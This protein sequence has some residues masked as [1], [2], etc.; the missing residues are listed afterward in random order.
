V[1][2]EAATRTYITDN[3]AHWDEYGFGTWA[4]YAKD[5]ALRDKAGAFA[6]RCA[7]RHI[8]I[9]DVDEVELGY[10]FARDYW[11]RGLA[12]EV[13]R[14]VLEIGFGALRLPNIIAFADAEH[15]ASRHVME[16]LGFQ[17]EYE[18]E[19]KGGWCALYRLFA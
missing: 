3:I 18:G 19:I 16:K 13:S 12:T 1:R 15:R 7:L 8:T 10:T 6:G 2:D 4:L 9:N 17:F 11:G 5:G 14:S